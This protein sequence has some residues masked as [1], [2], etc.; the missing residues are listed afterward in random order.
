M[1]AS[2]ESVHIMRGPVKRHPEATSE[3][4]IAVVRKA[5]KFPQSNRFFTL[6]HHSAFPFFPQNILTPV[7]KISAAG[8][9]L[10]FSLLHLYGTNDDLKKARH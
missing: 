4:S 10:Y 6:C 7:H 3:G 8:E 2:E 9:I 1:N 5:V